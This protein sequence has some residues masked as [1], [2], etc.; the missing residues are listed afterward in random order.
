M[1][2]SE[3]FGVL[4]LCKPDGITSRDLVNRVQRLIRPV[5]VGHAGTLDPM[6]TG[7]LLVCVGPA[8]RLISMLQE[9]VKTYATEF[10]LGQSSDTDDSTG[11]I[12]HQAVD[13]PP[14]R[15]EVVDHLNQMTGAI[16][17]V[18]PAFSAVHVQGQR[19]YALARTG[20]AV[21]LKPKQ[22]HIHSIQVLRYEWPVLE[23]EISC[24]SGT[25][26]RSIARDLGR[27]LGCGGLMSRL[28]RTQVG[29]FSVSD[30]VDANELAA[31][32]IGRFICPAIRIVDGLPKI[33]CTAGDVRD[34]LCGRPL[35]CETDRPSQGSQAL[36][37]DKV[38]LTRHQ[39]TELLA[40][41]EF[42]S[43]GLLQPRTVFMKPGE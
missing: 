34:L 18:P 13:S 30:S 29:S 9:G 31:E 15:Q 23:L 33:D 43:D 4:N 39:F 38:A 6:A 26:I 17:Q 20:Q 16:S 27:K 11:K 35:H 21:E 19:A 24:G 42:T 41:A 12:E 1:A 40:L 7:V 3:L 14:T 28:E 10:T 37:G 32:N 8:T 36:P 2:S 5:K 25:Y 22:V